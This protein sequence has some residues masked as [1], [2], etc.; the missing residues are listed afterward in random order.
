L[1]T[2]TGTITCTAVNACGS[3]SVTTITTTAPTTTPDAPTAGISEP[4]PCIGAVGIF[5]VTASTG[6]SS[7]NWSISG[8]GWG[9]SGSSGNNVNLTAGAG[10][11]TVTVTA[12]NGCGTSAAFVFTV[13]S[14]PSSLPKPTLTVASLPCGSG[15]TAVIDGSSAGATSYIWNV[16]GTGW[17]GTSTTGTLDAL[18]GTATGT[19]V[20]TALNTCGTSLP[21][22]I[23][24]APAP[25]LPGTATTI[26]LPSPICS[27]NFEVFST[28]IVPYATTYSWSVSGAGWSGSSTTNSITL[29]IGAS[30]ATI[31]VAG[32]N[33]CGEAAPYSVTVIPVLTPIADFSIQNHTT[34]VSAI[35]TVK[36]TGVGYL[37][38][39]YTW[40]FGT[41]GFGSPGTGSGPQ[42]VHWT[43]TGLKTITLSVSDSG[44]TST[45]DD[46]VLVVNTLNAA[47][48]SSKDASFNIIPNPNDGQ[49][50]VV[51]GTAMAKP[52]E[53]RLTD[54]AGRVVYHNS[55]G[56]NLSKVSIT[57]DGL[58]AGTYLV[59]LIVD[60][61]VSVK[62]IT[63]V[64]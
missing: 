16:S 43:T 39:T 1:G 24:V 31:T 58:A 41:S 50:N 49:F 14:T 32:V 21:D 22:T 20:C 13:S 25:A 61:D 62:T 54:M 3:S 42:A 28:P 35:D 11:G 30:P 4:S 51:F 8:T 7:Y 48:L 64:R 45:T 12:T 47:E 18:V 9:I 46:T 26:N 63:L 10:V 52:F 27:G 40:T 38:T 44:C 17:S 55:Y 33:G 2:G 59:S 57:T 5:S 34:I 15:V 19:I 29:A 23:L 6:A 36:F 56:A 60:N 53:I 37:A